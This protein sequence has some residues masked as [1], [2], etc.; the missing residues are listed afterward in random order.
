MLWTQHLFSELQ[1]L[2]QRLGQIQKFQAWSYLLQR[3]HA[4]AMSAA[5]TKWALAAFSTLDINFSS[6]ISSVFTI[7]FLP[8]TLTTLRNTR[9][10]WHKFANVI[11]RRYKNCATRRIVRFW[12]TEKLGQLQNLWKD[13]VW[14]WTQCTFL[15]FQVK[16]KKKKKKN[17]ALIL[18]VE[19]KRL[20][21]LPN[22]YFFTS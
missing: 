2:H 9:F 5:T 7:M 6:T 1:S 3:S 18:W 19:E 15:K 21:Y 17:I 22:S 16:K 14:K 11:F 20:H 8:S 10:D 12:E 13:D 4:F